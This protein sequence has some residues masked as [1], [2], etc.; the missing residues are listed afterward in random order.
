M[1]KVLATIA[2]LSA[3]AAAQGIDWMT[4]LEKARSLARKTN[5]PMLAVFR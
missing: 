1:E 2:L 4:D 5:R 3:G